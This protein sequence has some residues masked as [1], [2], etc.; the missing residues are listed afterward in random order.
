MIE[1]PESQLS[2]WQKE[3]QQKLAAEGLEFPDGP[4][5]PPFTHCKRCHR[6]IQEA[7]YAKHYRD[8]PGFASKC[9]EWNCSAAA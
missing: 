3:H 4:E 9:E 5:D 8:C 1:R 6:D 2:N 7:E